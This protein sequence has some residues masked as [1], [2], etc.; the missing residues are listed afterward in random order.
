MSKSL[1]SRSFLLRKRS[2]IDSSEAAFLIVP[3]S[4]EFRSRNKSTIITA[5]P[6]FAHG[7]HCFTTLF[8]L[9]EDVYERQNRKE[10]YE[11]GEVEFYRHIGPMFRNMYGLSWTNPEANT[12]HGMFL[13]VVR[14]LTEVKIVL[15]RAKP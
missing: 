9:I 5:P 1:S 2:L 11:V 4:L 10:G 13:Y 3:C 7:V 8:D 6:K 14:A 15:G 12:K